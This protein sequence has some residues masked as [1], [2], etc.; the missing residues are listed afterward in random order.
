MRSRDGF[1][2][3]QPM[4]IAIDQRG[5]EACHLGIALGRI[6]ASPGRLDT[7]G[8]HHRQARHGRGEIALHLPKSI[9]RSIG[10]HGT[11]LGPDL[12][13]VVVAQVR[14]IGGPGRGEVDEE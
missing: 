10:A 11:G 14:V 5:D 4:Q 1:L 12:E 13:G 3:F 6:V 7:Q 8:G 2:G 9:V